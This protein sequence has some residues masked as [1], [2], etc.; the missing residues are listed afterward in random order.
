MNELK[1]ENINIKNKTKL[2]KLQIIT[3]LS[4]MPNFEIRLLEGIDI[5][6]MEDDK[7]NEILD[8]YKLI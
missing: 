1:N 4:E 2:V 8:F 7:I 6:H 5:E 3:K